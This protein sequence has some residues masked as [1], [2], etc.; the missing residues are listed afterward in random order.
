ME[1][2]I[3]TYHCGHLWSFP[4]WGYSTPGLWST[5]PWAVN[6]PNL[7]SHRVCLFCVNNTSFRIDL[8]IRFQKTGRLKKLNKNW[9][10]NFGTNGVKNQNPYG[11]VVNCTTV[12]R[13]PTLGTSGVHSDWNAGD[14]RAS[15]HV[16]AMKLKLMKDGDVE[17]RRDWCCW[18]FCLFFVHFDDFRIH[19]ADVKNENINDVRL[20]KIIIY[21]MR[22]LNNLPTLSSSCK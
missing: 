9:G 19:W 2:K 8:V 13:I 16:C 14:W 21:L 7:S 22:L 4:K 3:L 10:Q 17:E 5:T 20:V 1:L 6:L 15:V 18:L 11:D 12:Q